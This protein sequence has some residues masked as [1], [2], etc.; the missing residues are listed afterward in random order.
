MAVKEETL[1]NEGPGVEGG[2]SS[3]SSFFE[4]LLQ[5]EWLDPLV[6]CVLGIHFLLALFVAWGGAHF[7]LGPQAA[8]L[9]SLVICFSLSPLA[10]RFL[11]EC[12]DLLVQSGWAS[13]AYADGSGVWV[14]VFWT[15]PLLGLFVFFNFLLSR[16]VWGAANVALRRCEPRGK[17]KKSLRSLKK[18]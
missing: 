11:F 3:A 12:Q 5:T 9:A 2:G 4:A 16:Q 8:A 1:P 7:R 15:A 17:G 18:A 10:E 13:R 6:I 14:F